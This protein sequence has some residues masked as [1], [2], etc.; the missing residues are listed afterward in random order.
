MIDRKKTYV[1]ERGKIYKHFKLALLQSL[2]LQRCDLVHLS[3]WKLRHVD[4]VNAWMGDQA[5]A[6]YIL[7]FRDSQCPRPYKAQLHTTLVALLLHL[8]APQ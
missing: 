8:I 3:Q 7:F 1:T 6:G 4:V 2:L 5:L